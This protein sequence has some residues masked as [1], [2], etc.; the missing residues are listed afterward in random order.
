[1]AGLTTAEKRTLLEAN[2]EPW[3]VCECH[4][5]PLT[6]HKK[7]DGRKEGGTWKCTVVHRE[8]CR[9][10]QHTLKGVQRWQRANL[11]TSMARLDKRLQE[12]GLNG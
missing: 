10:S 1:M 5:V 4:G 3:P 6:W 2:G 8:R 7:T 9:L 12:V 11:K